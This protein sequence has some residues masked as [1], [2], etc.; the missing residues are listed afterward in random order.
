MGWPPSSSANFA[1]P[2]RIGIG[3]PLAVSTPFTTLPP[4]SAQPLGYVSACVYFLSTLKATS[5]W[6]S[7]MLSTRKCSFFIANFSSPTSSNGTEQCLIGD[8]H[9]LTL[10]CPALTPWPISC[11]LRTTTPQRLR[12]RTWLLK[13][14]GVVS[15]NPTQE[16]AQHCFAVYQSTMSRLGDTHPGNGQR[17]STLGVVG[18]CFGNAFGHADSHLMDTRVILAAIQTQIDQAVGLVVP[19]GLPHHVD[20][21]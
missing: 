12:G 15:D 20:C 13:M 6:L 17:T 4:V 2:S 18:A 8:S 21:P 14:M 7:G 5:R 3:I 11:P 10:S 16:Q 1:G 19:C 9:L